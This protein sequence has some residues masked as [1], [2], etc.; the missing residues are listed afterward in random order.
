PDPRCQSHTVRDGDLPRRGVGRRD[1][2]GHVA[3]GVRVA[4]GAERA[5]GVRP[6]EESIGGSPTT[7]ETADVDLRVTKFD[8]TA[9]R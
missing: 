7:L 3:R 6:G 9:S 4:K 2:E 5:M 8:R 1:L